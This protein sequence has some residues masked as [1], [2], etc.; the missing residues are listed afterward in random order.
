[1]SGKGILKPKKSGNTEVVAHYEDVEAAIPV[2]V[3]FV[4]KLEVVNSVVSIKEGA[5][6]VPIQLKF[7][8]ANNRDLGKRGVTLHPEGQ[9]DRRDRRRQ[10][11]SSARRG[12]KTTA[13]HSG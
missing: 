9:E 12:G 7:L 3:S 6:A 5:E 2:K 13:R 4:E 11:H 8:G 1:M 10:R